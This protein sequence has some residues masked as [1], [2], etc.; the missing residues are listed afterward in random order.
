LRE[1]PI[2]RLRP[3]V[4]FTIC[5]GAGLATGL[6]RFWGPWPALLCLL[7]A[8]CLRRRAAVLL[9][10][11]ALLGA[12]HGAVAVARAGHQCASRLPAGEVRLVVRLVEP[13]GPGPIGARARGCPGRILVR[14][15]EA[16]PFPAGTTLSLRGRW[17]PRERAVGR[18]DGVL[19]AREL[20][21]APGPPPSSAMRLR[22]AIVHTAEGMFGARAPMVEA[23][24]LGR[25]GGLDPELRGAF[26]GAGLAHILAISGFHVGLLTGWLALV[27]RL[28]RLRR[29]FA[30][31]GAA[32]GGLVYVALLGFPTPAT[33]AGVL[34][35]LL[36]WAWLRQRRVQPGALLAL[37]ALAV[38]LVDP[39]ALTE[40]GA[41]LSAA[42]VWGLTTATRWSDTT[43]GRGP[44]ARS[45]AA[46]TGATLATAP[47]TAWAF[48]TVAPIGVG[49]NL[50]AVP[51]ATVAVPGVALTL[52]TASLAP[53]FSAAVAA[54]TG[55]A[56]GVLERVA[57]WGSAL[58]GGTLHG[59]PGPGWTF[60]AGLGLL[61]ACWV[62]SGRAT[63][64]V[65]LR[66]VAWIVTVAAWATLAIQ[67]LRGL[68][69]AA[70]GL[71]LFVLDVG[72]GDAA[73]IR[74]PA[75]RW[76]LVDA[77]PAFRGADAGR[78]VVSPFLARQGTRR[79]EA[80]VL[81]HAHLDHVG[82]AGA[83]MDRF[84]VQ[85]VIEPALPVPDSAYLALLDRVSAAGVAWYPARAGQAWELDGV[86]FRVLHPDTLWHGWQE[87]LNE[88]SLVLL[89]EYGG[90]R[91]VFAGDAGFPAEAALRDRV[92]RVDLLK[93]GHH[94]S[95][96]AT[97]TEW[98]T[99]LRPRAVV[100]S[101]GARNRY[102][103]PAPATVTRIAAAGAELWRTDRDGTVRVRT[104]GRRVDV[105]GRGRRQSWVVGSRGAVADRE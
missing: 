87:S 10:V 56:L 1:G 96:T 88:D 105:S 46:S 74:T 64:R 15:P 5:F 68:G 2:L 92:G 34:G 18:P 52:L 45:L 80:L 51:A 21:V 101:L 93:A 28:A 16:D 89:V 23:L 44:L 12:F 35:L 73:A 22:T 67:P 69:P 97:G 19:V 99:E 17:V 84:G 104:D 63:R 24:V 43:W 91:A 72:Q 102:G 79:V 95:R 32:L 40:V 20:S 65:A 81:S 31:M 13:A 103:H 57:M 94:G 90:F 49:L 27:L 59:D 55:V 41:W 4:A 86:T 26:A 36:A 76:V 3:V 85:A 38:L 71:T 11:A 39:W 83:V 53:E 70:R 82:G 78:R 7:A 33:R 62:I 30:L 58:P 66:R 75:G 6:L 50:V 60:L 42:A 54:G 8:W 14:L 98:L 9:P 77:G 29:E 37:T 47:I 25:R 48:G 61:L 100:L